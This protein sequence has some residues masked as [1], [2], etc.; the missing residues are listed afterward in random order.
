MRKYTLFI[1]VIFN[2][3]TIYLIL[4]FLLL[5]QVSRSYA[6]N[7]ELDLSTPKIEN[8]TPENIVYIDEGWA[9]NTINTTIYRHHGIVTFRN[10]QYLAFFVNSQRL[11]IVRNNIKSNTVK[12][13]ISDIV[14]EYDV[15]DSHN[16]IS[17]GIDRLGYIHLSY[18][19]HATNLRYRRSKYPL[20]ISDWTDEL[21]MTGMS[22]DRVT[23]P[24]FVIPQISE[25]N[26]INRELLFLYRDGHS[27]KGDICIKKYIADIKIWKDIRPCL[28]SGTKHYPWTSNAY[29]NHPSIDKNGNIH[30]S[31]VWRTHFLGKNRILNNIGVD[32]AV[33][34]DWAKTWN[35]SLGRKYQLP[36]TQV[37]S[38]T[39]FAVSPGNNLINQTSSAVDSKGNPHIVFYSNDYEGIP[40]YQHVWFD[41]D[42]WNHSFLSKRQKTFLLHGAGSLD[43]PISRPE[44]VIDNKD[45]LYL[46]YRGDLSDN[47]MAIT[48]FL[49]P[50][51]DL[52]S[53]S[54]RILW[55]KDIGYAEPII[56]R[57]RWERDKI[58]SMYMQKSGRASNQDVS[59]AK[60]EPAYIVDWDI[61][62][63]W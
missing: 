59:P 48:R 60:T 17:I 51:Y 34:D 6:V 23:Y 43:I 63:N 54:T 15:S 12:P 26:S 40:Q 25:S 58:L 9:N 13:Q 42:K 10:Y 39:V 38:E 47:K 27:A 31:Y 35:T 3:G 44:V 33:S 56:D 28:L 32:Y 37:N 8:I 30:L 21:S 22:E 41:G 2:R 20:S 49:P 45:R 46:I 16:T 36:I 14:G 4:L 18:S 5:V 52:K 7:D 1:S 24:T 29:L 53:S 57:L 11:R 55:N 19:Q 61:V 50:N 62:N